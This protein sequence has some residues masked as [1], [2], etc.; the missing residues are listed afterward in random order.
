MY[1]V[2]HA[3]VAFLISYAIAKKLKIGEISFALAMLLACLPDIDILFQSAG[4]LPHKSYI[5]SLILSLIVVPAVILSIAKWRRVSAGAAFIY[6][7]AYIQH[8]A[9]GDIMIGGTNIL[10]PFG[11]LMVGTGIGYGTV[12]H[13]ALE[14]LLLAAT[15]GIIVSKSF[16][17]T[18]HAK[19]SNGLFNFSNLDK[20]SYALLMTS[21]VVSFAYLLYGVKVLPRLFIQTNLELALFVM[22]HLSAIVVISFLMLVSRQHSNLQKKVVKK[23]EQWFGGSREPKKL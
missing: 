9:V 4:I 19:D 6:S 12:A 3:V 7:L 15:A 22:L 2:G 20:I 11:E 5:H 18:L 23:S 10:Y 8:I 13:S 14:F 16:R 17:M 21:F 1:L